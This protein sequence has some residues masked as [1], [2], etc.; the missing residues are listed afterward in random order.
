[1]K[2]VI[3]LNNIKFK[4]LDKKALFFHTE[5]ATIGD[6][7]VEVLKVHQ[8]LHSGSYVFHYAGERFELSLKELTDNFLK[9]V[10][11]HT[12]DCHVNDDPFGHK[13]GCN[14]ECKKCSGA[15]H[16]EVK[17][18]NGKKTVAVEF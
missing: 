10:N 6:D 8:N 3:E 18:E 15:K 9:S 13:L 1:M 7:D 2:N 11:H 5:L 12:C 14:I 16:V 17:H 4:K